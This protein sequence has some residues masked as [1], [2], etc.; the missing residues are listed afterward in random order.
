MTDVA[1]N[2]PHCDRKMSATE[3]MEG[4]DISC[5]SCKNTLTVP[6]RII[7]TTLQPPDPVV[8]SG[9]PEIGGAC[10]YCREEVTPGDVATVCPTCGTPHHT[11]CWNENGGCT[12]FGCSQ[13]PSEEEKISVAAPAPP[14]SDSQH[15]STSQGNPTPLGSCPLCGRVTGAEK[16]KVLY[17]N[18]VCRKCYHSFANRRQFAFLLDSVIWRVATYPLG[19]MLGTLMASS[20]AS[21]GDIESMSIVCQWALAAAFLCKDCLLGQSPGKA[22]CGVKVIEQG[23][24]SPGGIGASFKRNLPLVIPFMPLI[25]AFQLCKGHRTGD[26]WSNTKVIWKKY[27]DHPLFAPNSELRP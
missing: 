21:M 22:I 9:S 4:V 14:N 7:F 12:V 13:A 17:G 27:A 18:T 1:F 5:P 19:F 10:P 26:D 2:C 16:R 15:V 6:I 11:D 25:V 20:G 23:T 8:N 24:G 3:D